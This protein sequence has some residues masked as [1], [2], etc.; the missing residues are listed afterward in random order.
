[1]LALKVY[2]N[3]KNKIF[4]LITTVVLGKCL[5]NILSRFEPLK[6]IAVRLLEPRTLPK[7]FREGALSISDAFCTILK[8][9]IEGFGC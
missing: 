8:E 6:V 7:S 1:M 5:L 3:R 9:E 2:K 4:S